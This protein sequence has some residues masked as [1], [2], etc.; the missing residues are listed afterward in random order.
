M[1]AHKADLEAGLAGARGRVVLVLIWL[2][3]TGGCTTAKVPVAGTEETP[4]PARIALA[5]VIDMARVYGEGQSARLPLTG[6]MFVTGEVAPDVAEL[7]TTETETILRDRG[8]QVVPPESVGSVMETLG[9][10]SEFKPGQREVILA[11]A[12]QVEAEAILVGYLY[13]IHGRQGGRFAVRQPASVAYG[14]Y[15]VAVDGG[16]MLWSGE[17][18]ETQRSLFENLFGL[19]DFIRRRGEWVSATRMATDSVREILGDF[20]APPGEIGKAD[21]P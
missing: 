21:S 11:S 17:F 10:R 7:L 1:G 4:I 3:L 14:L 5:P 12:R 13:R 15:L 9:A 6:K 2:A 8:F 16:R 19:G 18:D 20:P